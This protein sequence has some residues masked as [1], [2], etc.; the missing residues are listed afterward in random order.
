MVRWLRVVIPGGPVAVVAVIW[1]V[2]E[3]FWRAAEAVGG[4]PGRLDPRA[5]LVV[6][7]FFA[8][9]YGM[10]RALAFHPVANP[11]Y[12]AWL[13][14]TPWTSRKPL[15]A[16]PPHLVAQDV[17]LVGLALA[18]GWWTAGP[19]ALAV[20][21]LFLAGYLVPLA[22]E[23]AGTGEGLYAYAVGFGLGL[24][25]RLL[26]D[27]PLALAAAA[28]TYL[29]AY[30]GLRQS[31][32]NFP[33]E[34]PDAP[35]KPAVRDI[36]VGVDPLGW[37]FARLG[38]K[39]ADGRPMSLRNALLTSLLVGWWFHALAALPWDPGDRAS[40]LFAGVC[41]AAGLAPLFRLIAYLPGYAPPISLLGRLAT[42]RWL[43]PGYDQVF[44]A[45]LLAAWIGFSLPWFLVS[46]GLDSLVAMPLTL[47][48][49]LFVVLAMGPDR[50]TWRLTGHHRIVPA[51]LQ[52]Q[53]P[54]QQ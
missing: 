12:R 1:G 38:P 10:Y 15:P 52:A 42:G 8:A 54:R 4:Q 45:P 44:V 30:A 9:I 21:L 19:K 26:P 43:I 41:L 36:Q 53:A 32:R 47:G 40:L 5:S 37:P 24:V 22:L 28:A 20:P 17:V 50:K 2:L 29:V 33:W 13:A 31:L 27:L 34:R 18:L 51:G 46:A 35:P 6:F 23:L 14:A 25:V 3:G 11:R 7:E 16:G 49:T 39:F 48:L